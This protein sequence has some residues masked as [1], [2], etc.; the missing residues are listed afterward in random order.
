MDAI[1]RSATVEDVCSACEV[2]RR[3]I[4]ECCIDDHNDDPALVAEWLKDKT[5]EN[6]AAWIAAR[7]S[8]AVVADADGVIVGIAAFTAV[9]GITLCYLLPEARRRGIGKALLSALEAEAVRRRLLR[10][11][12][13]STRAA[14]AF[15]M[16]HGYVS[17]AAAAAA[18][19]MQPLPMQKDL[20][21]E[22]CG[23]A[24]TRHSDLP[25]TG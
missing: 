5:P 19:V 21:V 15:F 10:L 9:G 3:S 12:L 1:I 24:G 25:V 23:G 4:I 17:S 13:A 2:V 22:H 7:G 16:R 11:H 20:A 14:R 8:Y 6:L 18:T